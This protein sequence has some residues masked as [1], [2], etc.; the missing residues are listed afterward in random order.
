MAHNKLSNAC[1]VTDLRSDH[2]QHLARVD[3]SVSCVLLKTPLT[4]AVIVVSPLTSAHAVTQKVIG[5]IFRG[6]I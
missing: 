3:A 2:K 4:Q 6:D 5:C 1:Q